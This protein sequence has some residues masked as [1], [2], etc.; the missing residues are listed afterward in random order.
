ME[1]KLPEKIK[2][3][4]VIVLIIGILT[5][6]C[7]SGRIAYEVTDNFECWRPNYEKEDISLI[8]DKAELEDEDY[9]TLYAQTGLTKIGIDRARERG[10]SGK[11]R[12]LQIQSDYF[13]K[14]TVTHYKFAPYICTCNIGKDFIQNIYLED[15]D[16]IVTSSTQFF[17]WRMGHAGIVTDGSNSFVLQATAIG[18]V[19]YVG[20]MKDFTNRITFMVLSPKVDEKIKKQVVNYATKNLQGIYYNPLRGAFSPKN[21]IKDTQCSHIV[22]YAYNQFGIDLDSNGGGIVTPRDLANSPKMELVQVFGFDPQKLW[23]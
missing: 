9:A 18:D 16:V 19:S 2:C 15:G 11:T 7:T 14:H 1:K 6:I 23:K 4:A 8:L 5:L 22:W 17:G 10:A 21:S 3:V 13:E 20:N 12:V